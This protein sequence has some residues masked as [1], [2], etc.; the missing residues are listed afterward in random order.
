MLPRLF[1]VP[2]IKSGNKIQLCT[3]FKITL[4]PKLLVDE[5]RLPTTEKGLAWGDKFT[6]IDLKAVYL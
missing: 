6:K 5:H 2:V 1:L 4:N 3:D